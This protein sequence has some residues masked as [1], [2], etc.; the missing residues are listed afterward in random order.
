MD[1]GVVLAKPDPELA[2][3]VFDV[4]DRGGPQAQLDL[5]DV[6]AGAIGKTGSTW[7]EV[8]VWR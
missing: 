2:Q 1:V 4:A 3:G 7:F 5:G 8:M 6:A